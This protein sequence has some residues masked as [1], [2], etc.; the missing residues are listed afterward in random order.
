MG[1]KLIH[2]YG[3]RSGCLLPAGIILLILYM[4]C[5]AY[6]AANSD[7][8]LQNGLKPGLSSGAG[9]TL[10]PVQNTSTSFIK[11]IQVN[12][13]ASTSAIIAWTTDKP[14]SGLVQ[15]GKT[16]D[17][18]FA[19]Q[20]NGEP[21][22]QQ[23]VNLTGLKPATTYHYSVVLQDQRGATVTSPDQSFTTLEQIYSR[24]LA[25]SGIGILKVTGNMAT[26]VW[27]TDM[28]AT[29]QIEY[30]STVQYGSLAELNSSYI[31]NHSI[32]LEPLSPATTYHY[33]IISHD[34]NGNEA[35]STDQSFTTTAISDNTP[36]VI[37][38]VVTTDITHESATITWV[39]NEL[40]IGQVEYDTNFSY[41]NTTP[42]ETSMLLNHTIV[43]NNLNGG[44]PYHFRVNSSDSS[45]NISTSP[46]TTFITAKPPR[47]LG[48]T[49]YQHLDCKCGGYK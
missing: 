49:S 25:I 8:S 36:P 43:L 34:K 6:P 14:S 30:G 3:I 11:D 2:V 5:S 33:R 28:P 31:P 15:W 17:Y 12:A 41:G 39:T 32:N 46:D 27:V 29:G 21:A 1:K 7:N 4:G 13:I 24:P 44:I 48:P 20:V 37:S 38:D 9:T 23:S 10:Q 47:M 22:I 18:G 26:V 16:T 35:T 45:G 42:P 19:T 40:A